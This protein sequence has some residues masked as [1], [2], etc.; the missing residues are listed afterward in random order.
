M[1]SQGENS[2]HSSLMGCSTRNLLQAWSTR[3]IQ[4]GKD[5]ASKR[6]TLQ[7]AIDSR[8]ALAKFILLQEKESLIF[9]LKDELG[10]SSDGERFQV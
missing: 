4:T 6:L 8:D 3:N 10:K 7:Q 9:D 5:K 1:L 2:V